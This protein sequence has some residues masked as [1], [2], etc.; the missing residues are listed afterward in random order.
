MG[1]PFRDNVL[2]MG[3]GLGLGLG[4]DQYPCNGVG[5]A[6]GGPPADDFKVTRSLQPAFG[7]PC[8]LN[9]VCG[10]GVGGY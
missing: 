8:F 9:S 4:S 2:G 3:S 6:P 1:W 10:G 7:K 5:E